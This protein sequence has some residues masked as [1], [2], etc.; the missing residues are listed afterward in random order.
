MQK[1][2]TSVETDAFDMVENFLS[3]CRCFAALQ[4]LEPLS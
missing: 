2:S 4:P 1:K 3:F